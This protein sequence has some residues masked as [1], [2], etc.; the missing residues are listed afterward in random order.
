MSLRRRVRG[1]Q[2]LLAA[3]S[4]GLVLTGAIGSGAAFAQATPTSGVA[5]S[6]GYTAAGPDAAGAA[7]AAASAPSP[8]GCRQRA[9]DPHKSHHQAGRMNA[10]VR[11]TCRNP[12]P[13]MQHSAQLW[14]TRWWGWDRIGT[15][16]HFNRAG[17]SRGSAF[18]NDRCRNN[19]I[20]VTGSGQI[21]DVD[22]RTYY[23]STESRHV[24]IDC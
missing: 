19:N 21:T 9:H 2:R 18:A 1:A 8:S 22:G 16:G 3:A 10:E 13:R 4:L 5:D 15:V 17:V 23:A 11:A 6:E 24:E 12:V 7:A 14:E 20:R